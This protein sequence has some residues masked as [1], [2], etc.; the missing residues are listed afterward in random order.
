MRVDHNRRLYE[1]SAVAARYATRSGL[2]PAEDAI[3]ARYRRDIA[4]R[5]ILDIG[6]GGGR[7]T[8]FL[9]E[10]SAD[11]IGVDY[12]REMIDR[13]RAR[14]RG[15]C[16]QV[17]DARDLSC[18]T[19]CSFDFVLFSHS[20]IDAVDHEGRLAVLRE[21]RRVLS[22]GGLFVFS[23]HNR[24]FPIPKPWNPGRLAMNPLRKPLAFGMRLAS[25]PVGMVNYVRHARSAEAND[26]YCVSVDSAHRYSLVHYRIAAGAQKRQL[27]RAGFGDICVFDSDGRRLAW[28]EA[29][30]SQV[31][32]SLQYVCRRKG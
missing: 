15:T 14:F 27:E 16:F 31:D 25:Y 23:S 1:S 21:A 22:T 24:R 5:R 11:Y 32:P 30:R 29:E 28:S 26:D 6:V 13:C 4:G 20:G 10:L 8:P 2:H 12:S 18:F 9:L 19:D 17:A 7:T 3:I